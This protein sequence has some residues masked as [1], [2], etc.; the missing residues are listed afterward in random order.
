MTGTYFPL[1]EQDIE[2]LS[3]DGRQRIQRLVEKALETIQ[4]LRQEES[5]E[6]SAEHDQRRETE[7]I[8]RHYRLATQAELDTMTNLELRDLTCI[9]GTMA[10]AER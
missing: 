6:Q 2:G 3:S 10:E 5:A 9:M 7:R 8:L 1:T 4:R